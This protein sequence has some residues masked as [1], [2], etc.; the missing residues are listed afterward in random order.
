M[1]N[2][3]SNE[4]FEALKVF[5]HDTY[6]AKIVSGGREILKR[7]HICGDSRDLSNAHMYI[8][9]RNG[10][11]VYNCFKCNSKGLVDGEFLRNMGCYDANLASLCNEQ[12]NK[13]LKKSNNYIQGKP[14]SSVPLIP[15]S[16][17]EIACNK[18]QYLSNRLGVQINS[19][20]ASNLKIILN[21]KEFLDFNKVQFYTRN[22][23]IIE[24]LN[25]Y[26][27]GFL[28]IDNRYVILRRIIPEGNLPNFIDNRYVDYDII[29]GEESGYKYYVI[30]GKIRFDMP[31]DIHIAE[32][33]FDILSIYLNLPHNNENAIYASIGGKS[34]AA[35]ARF[36][37]TRY[38]LSNIN[39]HIYADADIS[40]NQLNRIWNDLSLFN[41]NVFIHRNLCS[42]EKD[43][44]VPSD[45]IIDSITRL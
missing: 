21:L 15:L 34:Y 27:I 8:G 38:G 39:L 22:P 44:G 7:C 3:V 9:Q 29:G 14:K 1:K 42:G 28:S 5:M 31:I 43:F 20:M 25:E 6:G 10:A 36:F 12:K 33:T 32:G 17:N 16:N 4:A 13:F 18:I 23:N 40:S 11:I 26:F 30:P 45:R 41:I 19:L 37:I 24:I 2:F 35:L